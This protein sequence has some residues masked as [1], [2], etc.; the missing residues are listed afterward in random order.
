MGDE[1]ER[2][3]ILIKVKTLDGHSY[4][5]KVPKDVRDPRTIFSFA[6]LSVL[7]LISRSRI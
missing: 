4:T 2:A 6:T 7:P 5:V 1:V 3:L